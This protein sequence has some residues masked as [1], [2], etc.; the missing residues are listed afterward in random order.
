[1]QV[2]GYFIG[3]AMDV[4]EQMY[5]GILIEF[6]S[7]CMAAFTIKVKRIIQCCGNFTRVKN[8]AQFSHVLNMQ[9]N[10]EEIIDED[11]LMILEKEVS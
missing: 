7:R 9:A 6:A 5:F 4:G 8:Q 2:T 3:L 10:E 1:L 11:G